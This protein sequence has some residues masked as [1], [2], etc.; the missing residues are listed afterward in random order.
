MKQP[1]HFQRK[2]LVSAVGLAL[3]GGMSGV[4]FADSPS[5]DE[6]WRKIE[7][8]QRMIEQQQRMIEE[9]RS[10][11]EQTEQVTNQ[12]QQQIDQAARSVKEV[13]VKTEM[14]QKSEA[15]DWYAGPSSGQYKDIFS[16]QAGYSYWI[17]DDDA[18]EYA[19]QCFDCSDTSNILGYPTEERESNLSNLVGGIKW[20]REFGRNDFALGFNF[21]FFK[22][23]INQ[24]TA[25]DEDEIGTPYGTVDSSSS[26]AGATNQDSAMFFMGDFEYGWHRNGPANSNVRLFAGI[27]AEYL[28]WEREANQNLSS[29]Q[30]FVGDEDSV[31]YGLGPRLGLSFDKPIS[32]SKRISLFGA[33]SGGFLVG[34]LERDWDLNGVTDEAAR[35]RD[36][37]KVQFVPFGESELGFGYIVANDIQLQLGYQAGYQHDILHTATVCTDDFD[38]D[39]KPD[40]TSCGDEDSGVLNHGPFMRFNWYF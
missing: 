32:S 17:P 7:E 27:R 37:D 30:W 13:E 16:V 25:L 10:R 15:E 39:V 14:A 2:L 11:L 33:I 36:E 26:N 20:T 1:N 35:Y 24:I 8:Q 9:M 19:I 4:A 34:K 23:D 28:N 5:N 29:S 12:H 22:T 3:S 6:L 31:F 18:R 38:D 40:N 21:G